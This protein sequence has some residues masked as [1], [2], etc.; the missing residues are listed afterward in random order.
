[1]LKKKDEETVGEGGEED[2]VSEKMMKQKAVAT[3]KHMLEEHWMMPKLM[4]EVLGG[5]ASIADM[6]IAVKIVAG[7]SAACMTGVFW[8]ASNMFLVTLVD[9]LRRNKGK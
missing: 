1:M 7:M 9:H 4:R 6:V 5:V 3:H 2:E 8:I